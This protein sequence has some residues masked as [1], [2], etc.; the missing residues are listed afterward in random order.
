VGF[1][2]VFICALSVG[3]N[4][5]AKVGF[6]IVLMSTI[7]FLIADR[8]YWD[9]AEGLRGGDDVSGGLA[10]LDGLVRFARGSFWATLTGAAILFVG[11]AVTLWQ[12][13][14]AIFHLS[15]KPGDGSS[16]AS[17]RPRPSDR[18]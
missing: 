5:A 2:F 7:A 6:A 1:L 3:L 10:R 15:R 17:S 9:A 12:R 13:R 4:R 11:C 18:A 8:L 16:Q 14:G